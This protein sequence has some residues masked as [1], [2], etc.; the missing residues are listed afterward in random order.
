M[1][2]MSFLRLKS[3]M[4]IEYWRSNQEHTIFLLWVLLNKVYGQF[5]LLHLLY[6]LIRDILLFFSETILCLFQLSGKCELSKYEIDVIF[7]V[8]DD[9]I[10]VSEEVDITV[11]VVVVWLIILLY[12]DVHLVLVDDFDVVHV[13]VNDVFVD[14]P[15]LLTKA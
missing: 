3:V 14:F 6:W 1:I 11:I 2:K 10:V 15:C 12:S 8:F 9:V 4:M 7:K 5:Q 13:S